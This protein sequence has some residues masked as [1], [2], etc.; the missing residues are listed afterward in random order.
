VRR[1]VLAWLRAVAESISRRTSRL[2]REL[3]TRAGPP[4]G[5]AAAAILLALTAA[6][7][8][9]CRSTPPPL[10]TAH[11]YRVVLLPVEGA[12]AAL[13]E[14]RGE[15]D[16]PLALTPQELGDAI[17]DRVVASHAFSDV[18]VADASQFASRTGDDAMAAAVDLARRSACDLILRVQVKRARMTDLGSNSSTLWSTVTWFMVPLPIWTV[19]DRSYQTD[20]A[21]QAELYDPADAARPTASIVATSGQQ[22]LDL[23]DRGLSPLVVVVPPA[24]LAG[25]EATVSRTLTERATD[26]LLTALVEELRTREIPSRFEMSVAEEKGSV[27]LEVASRRRL[28]SLDVEVDGKTA[29][30]WA[31]TALVEEADSTPERFVY[32]RTVDLRASP[33]AQVR[34]IAQD[35]SGGREVRTVVVGGATR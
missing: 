22:D 9:A 16:V 31:E 17:R 27:R 28:R 15:N 34:V 3:R 32:R 1:L 26:Q 18:V 25:S 6:T 21:V 23:W 2:Q 24:F 10:T 19:D 5:R 12:A 20:I 14:K 7:L 13:A 4:R 29:Q 11:P 33:G 8:A 30:S 35:E